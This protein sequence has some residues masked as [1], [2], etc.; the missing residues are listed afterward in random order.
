MLYQSEKAGHVVATNDPKVSV[1]H[2]IIIHFLL[3]LHVHQ[4][5]VVTRLVTAVS[6]TVKATTVQLLS[7]T[8][9]VED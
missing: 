8:C 7:A 3:T 9:Q 1:T 6:Q 4:E 5:H 2:I